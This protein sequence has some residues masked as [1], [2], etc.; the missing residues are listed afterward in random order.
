M[1][2]YH[3]KESG[4]M[5]K[6]PDYCCYLKFDVEKQENICTCHDWLFF[7]CQDDCVRMGDVKSDVAERLMAKSD[8]KVIKRLEKIL[9]GMKIDLPGLLGKEKEKTEEAIRRVEYE[10]L[11][12]KREVPWLPKYR[13]R[14]E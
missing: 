4:F 1:I 12:Y 9:S 14:E 8:P 5:N 7:D 3:F 6:T 2:V 11:R 13:N 10:M